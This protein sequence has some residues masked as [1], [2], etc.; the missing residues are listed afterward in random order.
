MTA[1]FHS[2]FMQ[3]NGNEDRQERKLRWFDKFSADQPPHNT[4]SSESRCALTKGA[5]SDVHER[6][7]T[8]DPFNFI[9]KHFLQICL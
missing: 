6:L 4:G 5:G 1:R 8:L 9:R 7:Y 2:T 3:I